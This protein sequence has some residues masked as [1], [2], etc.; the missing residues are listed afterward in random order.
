MPLALV[1]TLNTEHVTVKQRW[2]DVLELQK[3]NL[4][5]SD[6]GNRNICELCVK[7]VAQ[8]NVLN[9]QTADQAIRSSQS[10]S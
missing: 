5:N 4:S 1:D 7:Q 10:G 3:H 2:A 9:C 8:E 6:K